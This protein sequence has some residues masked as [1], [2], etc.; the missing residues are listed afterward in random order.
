MKP[1]RAAAGFTL[2][3]LLITATI[4]AVFATVAL[5]LAELSV[6]RSREN[7]LRAALR[8]I[9]G[10]LD[11]YKQAH[12]EGRML[13]KEGATGYPPSLEILVTGV[14]D[15]RSAK[16][17][18]I[19]FLRRLPRDPLHGDPKLPAAQT[20]GLRAYESP[21]DAPRSGADVYDIHSLASGVGLNGI[22]YA[23]W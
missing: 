5:P 15:A 11:A 16:K 22:P 8:E 17:Q 23:Q 9:R 10:A 21:F 13:K 7:E 1:R 14:E 12:D 2:I 6:K 18:R 19:N 4:V 20:W 3:E